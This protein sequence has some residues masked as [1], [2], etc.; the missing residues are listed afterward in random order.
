MNQGEIDI[1]CGGPCEDCPDDNLLLYGGLQYGCSRVNG[2]LSDVELVSLDSDNKKCDP[3]DLFYEVRDQETIITPKGIL[4]CGGTKINWN[5]LSSCTLQTT[6]GDTRFFPSMNSK[7]RWFGMV[8]IDDMI[9]AIGGY[10]SDDT[11]ESINIKDGTQWKQEFMPFKVR[12]HCVVSVNSKV[13]VIGGKIKDTKAIALDETWIY[14]TNYKNWTQGPSLNIKRKYHS[15]MVDRKTSTIYV[16]GGRDQIPN[17]FSSTESLKFD[18]ANSEWKM[19]SNLPES[20]LSS[21]AVSSK[22]NEFI[23]YVAGGS[24]KYGGAGISKI[25][26][27]RRRDME[28]IE[29]SKKLKKGRKHHSLVNA[30]TNEIPCR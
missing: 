29:L 21:S 17:D 2:Y 4:T 15:C 24:F 13:I 14:D 11:M 7:R 26:G 20:L 16:M 18:E 22:S 30:N 1:D 27:L 3:I 6:S 19:S 5:T 28:W 10:P 23:G 12:K 8:S 9:Y 25:Y